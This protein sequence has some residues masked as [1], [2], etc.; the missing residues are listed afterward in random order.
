MNKRIYDCDGIAGEPKP[1]LFI[2]LIESVVLDISIG[3][4]GRKTIGKPA[5]SAIVRSTK[6]GGLVEFLGQPRVYTP[7]LSNYRAT[8]SY[9]ELSCNC[10]RPPAMITIQE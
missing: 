6:N 5:Y 2:A 4:F 3:Y 8:L 7:S 9:I 1:S 10:I